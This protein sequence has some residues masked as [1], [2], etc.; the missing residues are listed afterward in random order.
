MFPF[1]PGRAPVR[2]VAVQTRALLLSAALLAATPAFAQTILS[3]DD[4]LRKTLAVDPAAAGAAA[5]LNASK[6]HARQADT[7]P[8]P[9]LGVEIE[10]F[11]GSGPFSKLGRTEATVSYQQTY[12]RG[13]KRQ[14]RTAL[15][16]SEIGLAQARAEVRR[17]DLAKAVQLAFVEVLAAQAQVTVAEDQLMIAQRAEREV[18][19]RVAGARDP[20]FAGA[21][22]DAELA[23]AR[24]SLDRTQAN[25]RNARAAL[26]AYWNGAA[27]FATPAE[28]FEDIRRPEGLAGASEIADLKLLAAEQAVAAARIAVEQT[29]AVQDPT[30]SLSVRH[31]QDEG[32]LALVV[33]ATIPLGRYDTNRGAI[34]RAR[35]ERLAIEA[36]LGA[37]RIEREREIARLIARRAAAAAE[38]RKTDAEVLPNVQRAVALVREGFNRGGFS[39]LDV[40]SA[41]R[42]LIE[43]KARRVE[44]LKA[45]HQDG[46]S[47]DRLTGA[48]AVLAST[49]T[50]P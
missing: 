3:L 49:E 4:A 18:S 39:Y 11:T 19:R 14:A 36:D 46:A 48:H 7:R 30:V 38:V 40:I 25:A 5:R 21:R 35:A 1:S 44:I 41:Q 2:R 28:L 31:L 42:A 32:A 20:L 13:G 10:N 22:A 15:A 47:L 9:S 50:Q 45:F 27:E 24:V 16:Q 33:G 8:N 6:A 12:E 34:D 29:R 17:L 37:L 26:V 43:A 23:Q